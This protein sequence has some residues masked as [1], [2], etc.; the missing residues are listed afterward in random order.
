MSWSDENDNAFYGEIQK[1][2]NVRKQIVNGL[3]AYYK[4]WRIGS[5]LRGEYDA[6]VP[7]Q[8]E[9]SM[10]FETKLVSYLTIYN[11]IIDCYQWNTT[12]LAVF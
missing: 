2:T 5:V 7:A 4:G 9:E 11:M 12:D 8:V 6:T 10:N 3:S 1:E